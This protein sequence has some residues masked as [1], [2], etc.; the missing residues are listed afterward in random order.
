MSEAVMERI[1]E[2]YFTTKEKGDGTG[3]GLSVVHGIVTSYGGY[4]KVSSEMGKR[5]EFSVFLPMIKASPLPD[6]NHALTP[7]PGVKNGSCWWMTNRRL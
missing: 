6:S 1:F 4:I 3:L 7:L 5:T 2:P